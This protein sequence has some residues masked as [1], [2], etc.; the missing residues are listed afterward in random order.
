MVV[1]AGLDEAPERRECFGRIVVDDLCRD[2][3]V[4][5][6]V[7]AGVHRLAV[8][9]DLPES[10]FDG[11]VEVGMG[12]PDEDRPLVGVRGVEEAELTVLLGGALARPCVKGRERLTGALRDVG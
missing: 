6:E 3:L 4:D 7:Q 10:G 8:D 12:E 1:A 11:V 2:D 5:R 9:D